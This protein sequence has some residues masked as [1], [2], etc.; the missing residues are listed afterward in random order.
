MRKC[1]F[2]KKT[3]INT[4]IV[5]ISAY[6]LFMSIYMLFLYRYPKKIFIIGLIIFVSTCLL[7]IIIKVFNDMGLYIENNRLF[8]K[9]LKSKEINPLDIV[10][11]KIIKSRISGGLYRGCYDLKTIK[12]DCLCSA[13]FL[14]KVEKK[15]KNFDKGDI[16]FYGEY[17]GC[18]MF[19]VKYDAE[20]IKKITKIN[21][22]IIII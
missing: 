8:Y 19:T 1:Y 10:G 4:T 9:C 7:F 13:I 21:S 15:M 3:H 11:I 5:C 22:E 17:K 12:G 16:E 20:M 18:I 6:M 14:N 2:V